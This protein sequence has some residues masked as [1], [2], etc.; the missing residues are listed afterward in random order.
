MAN[1]A[2]VKEWHWH[3]TCQGGSCQFLFLPQVQGLCRSQTLTCWRHRGGVG[4]NSIKSKRTAGLRI[5]TSKPKTS[6]TPLALSPSIRGEGHGEGG[7]GK[8]SPSPPQP[9]ILP[10]TL[11]GD[12]HTFW[13]T[14]FPSF[15]SPY[16]LQGKFNPYVSDS[17]ILNSSTCCFV[18]AIS[19]PSAFLK[20]NS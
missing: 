20:K 9:L 19:C 5:E 13:Q 1:V 10:Q 16:G 8:A 3:P 6:A 18:R 14:L 2:M 12:R 4:N 17:F 7:L 15:W 11:A